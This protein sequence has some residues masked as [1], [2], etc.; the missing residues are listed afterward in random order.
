MSGK[1]HTGFRWGVWI[2]AWW[3]IC[4]AVAA[5]TAVPVAYQFRYA[6]RIYEGVEV[7]GIPLGG[8]TLDEATRL[9]RNRLGTAIAAAPVTFRYGTRSWSLTAGELGVALDASGTA[10]AAYQVG[11]RG[12]ASA[13]WA[14][15]LQRNLADQWQ[16]WQA[17]Y[18][19]ASLLQLDENRLAVIL[20]QIGREVDQPPREAA[21]IFTETGVSG[22]AGAAGR[23]MDVEATQAAVLQVLRSGKGGI[24]PLVVEERQP[25]VVSVEVA[26]A[27]ANALLSHPV[28]LVLEGGGEVQRV[29][30]EPGLL[31]SWLKLSL[32]PP[33]AGMAGLA[34]SVDAPR[35]AA[36]VEGLARQFDRPA[37]DASLDYD[38]KNKQVVVLKPSHT[39]RAVDVPAAVEV[40]SR[41]LVGLTSVAVNEAV[42]ITLPV[43]TMWPVVD[44]TAIA[45]MGIKELVTQGTTYF[46]G[47]SAER[48]HNI[49]NA[50]QKFV[51]VVLPPAAEFSFNRIVGD[52]TATNGFIEGLIIWEDRTAVGI[53]GG[54]C[55]VSTTV[56]R[57]AV[58][59]GFPITERHAHGYVVSWYGE[60]GLD[61][62]IYTPHV[63]LRF[64]NDTGAFLLIKPE[65]DIVK[66]RITFSF[67]GTRPDRTVELSK[68][69]ISN[70]QVPE[71]PLYQEDRSLPH[72]T[73]KQV[74]WEK[75]GQDV[76]VTRTIRTG[77]GKVSE[78]RFVSKYQ[79]W[80]AVFLYGPGA[81]LP[82]D[83]IIGPPVPPAPK[84]P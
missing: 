17:G 83:A 6:D 10:V 18:A 33:T 36:R 5:I 65:V 79:P 55:Q 48:V 12:G 46:A 51:G 8:L 50:A 37:Q 39:G 53:G 59:G 73:I 31:R 32:A 40:I 61:A 30:V 60:P 54:V 23:L 63:D 58:Q 3:A 71:P 81:R 70:V 41:T 15:R 82:A 14:S 43:K 20:K 68:P 35:I 72:G 80:R 66:G 28:T 84:K 34:V 22:V 26:V 1:G 56:F 67:Y 45:E 52:I 29:A 27:Q 49:V 57:A 24:V 21:L 7:E 19:V 69:V 25:V 4:L 13:N 78:D 75:N 47:S 16:A 44:S 42:A 9:L 74:E 38:T 77:D 76:V 11:R 2:G 64:K 62:T